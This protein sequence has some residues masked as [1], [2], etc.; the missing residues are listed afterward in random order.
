MEP[1]IEGGI[2]SGT[3]TKTHRVTRGVNQ[4]DTR[5]IEIGDVSQGVTV[6]NLAV[7]S[8]KQ[9]NLSRLPDTS[10]NCKGVH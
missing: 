2:A 5:R 4:V 9:E 7:G 8:Y 6:G 3:I 1:S 10:C